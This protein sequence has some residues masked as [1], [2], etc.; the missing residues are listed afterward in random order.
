MIE[1][2][3][4]YYDNRVADVAWMAS[5]YH[6]YQFSMKEYAWR[7]FEECIGACHLAQMLGTPRDEVRPLIKDAQLRIE[8]ILGETLI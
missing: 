1:T 3:K 2:L 4:K 8:E 6:S 5:R 7:I